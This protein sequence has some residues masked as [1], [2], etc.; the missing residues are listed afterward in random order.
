LATEPAYH[1]RTSGGVADD[2]YVDSCARNCSVA[3]ALSVTGA[4]AP[5]YARTISSSAAF[6]A[7]SWIEDCRVIVADAGPP[8]ASPPPDPTQD[9]SSG[10]LP[11]LA[12]P[13]RKRRRDSSIAVMTTSVFQR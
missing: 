12:A 9:A 6:G 11:R 3:T 10:T 8:P 13:S 5:P 1:V 4:P 2:R 7:V